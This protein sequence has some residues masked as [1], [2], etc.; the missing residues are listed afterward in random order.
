MKR[1]TG[2]NTISRRA[3]MASTAAASIGQALFRADAEDA[4][5]FFEFVHY[6]LI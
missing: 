2:Y 3:F 4:A 1:D 6:G 5:F